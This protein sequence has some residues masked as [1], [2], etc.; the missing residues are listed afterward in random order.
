[1]RYSI[2]GRACRDSAISVT[3]GLQR[4]LWIQKTPQVA[5]RYG[6]ETTPHHTHF[7]KQT[8]INQLSNP[9]QPEW[10]RLPRAG[11]RCPY[12]NLS[13]ST[14]NNLILP[15]KANKNCPPV[16]SSVV[17]QKGATRGVRLIHRA[18]LMAYIEAG[19][20]TAFGQDAKVSSNGSLRSLK[21]RLSAITRV[22]TFSIGGNNK[23]KNGEPYLVQG[24]ISK[25]F[26]QPESTQPPAPRGSV[27]N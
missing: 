17:R 6:M 5:E 15:C 8:S 19:K 13:R 7:K 1:M 12:S 25:T 10:I 3:R 23:T 26:G 24:A 27:L 20:E 16:K 14:L 22:Q 11:E 2:Q 21:E 9:K 18:S 4:R